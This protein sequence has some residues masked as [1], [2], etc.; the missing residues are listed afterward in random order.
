MFTNGKMYEIHS[1]NSFF[2][3]LSGQPNFFSNFLLADISISRGTANCNA[4]V[5]LLY[6][7]CGEMVSCTNKNVYIRI[8]VPEDR[9]KCRQMR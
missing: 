3:S 8:D 9:A 6:K 5:D 1:P 4:N 7:V 2:S